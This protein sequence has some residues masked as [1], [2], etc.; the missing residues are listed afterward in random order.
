M[1]LIVLIGGISEINNCNLVQ[2]MDSN[3]S[4]FALIDVALKSTDSSIS[5]KCG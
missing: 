4:N 1:W 5:Y 3:L 2:L